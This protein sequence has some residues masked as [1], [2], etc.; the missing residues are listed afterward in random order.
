MVE[1]DGDRLTLHCCIGLGVLRLVEIIDKIYKAL[2][3][4]GRDD[5]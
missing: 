4:D 5:F 3:S 1:R 2:V